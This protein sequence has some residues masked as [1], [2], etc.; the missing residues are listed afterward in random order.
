MSIIEE[1]VLE[2]LKLQPELVA[3]ERG[4]FWR[5]GD[6]E[7]RLWFEDTTMPSGEFEL[8][9][10][11]FIETIF[12]K[13]CVALD[14]AT[15]AQ[16]NSQSVF[17][18]YFCRDERLG[19]RASYSV[20]A[21][22]PATNWVSLILLRAMGEQLALGY[23]IFQSEFVQEALPENRANLE[24]P[25]RWKVEPNQQV[26]TENAK[27]FRGR[28]FVATVGPHGLVLEVPLNDGAPSRMI[29]ENAETAI[30]HVSVDTPHPLAGVGYLATIALPIDP[31][32]EVSGFWCNFLNEKEHSEHDFVPRL[33][34]WGVRSMGTELVYSFFWPTD[35]A[36]TQ[37]DS[38]IMNWLVIRT[39]WLRENYWK[40]GYGLRL[41]KN[42]G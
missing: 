22:E 17:G 42:H 31:S 35:T 39:F 23:G 34:S 13:K 40:P 7:T 8:A 37:M 3:I 2:Q 12:G 32:H 38:T 1:K 29:D 19:M 41:E 11:A 10:I 28:G 18:N 21:K 25:R 4:F 5:R 24:Y 20:Y 6:D 14:T 27:R 33:G 26:L 15:L 36:D 30:L 16:L 9:S